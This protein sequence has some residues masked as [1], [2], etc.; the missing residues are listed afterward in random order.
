MFGE[1]ILR[2]ESTHSERGSASCATGPS[3]DRGPRG[4]G[5]HRRAD[6]RVARPRGGRYPRLRAGGAR[7]PPPGRGVLPGAGR[8]RHRRSL[9]GR[10]PADRPPR[11]GVRAVRAGRRGRPVE[12]A[13]RP[14]RG[15]GVPDLEARDPHR[16]RPR[17]GV[18][19][20]G[21]GP[22]PVRLPH[23][24]GLRELPRPQPQ[25]VLPAAADRVL[26]LEPRA[27]CGSGPQAGPA[28]RRG[29]SPRQPLPLRAR[30]LHRG[31]HGPAPAHRPVA[32]GRGRPR[33]RR[34]G[35]LPPAH[36]VRAV[37]GRAVHPLRAHR[38][39]RRRPD[40]GHGDDVRRH[41][42]RR[43]EVGT[44]A[45]AERGPGGGRRRRLAGGGQAGGPRRTS[46][47]C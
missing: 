2:D 21:E 47:R 30:R 12:A 14:P 7:A 34:L 32:G 24:R 5:Q 9:P 43:G 8:P 35:L 19:G 28:L 18:R 39:R 37:L 27:G 36:G 10:G 26:R 45:A 44:A 25:P 41:R 3:D 11:P 15:R 23:V 17:R 13:R 16:P 1:D 40:R 38:P 20:C 46:L 22:R 42:Y 31:A 29:R 4:R 33:R 6:R